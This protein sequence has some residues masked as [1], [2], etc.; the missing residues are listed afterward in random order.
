MHVVMKLF[1]VR[2]MGKKVL[3]RNLIKLRGDKEVE[4]FGSSQESTSTIRSALKRSPA[5]RQIIRQFLNR[6]IRSPYSN[7]WIVQK[8]L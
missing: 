8:I 2:I 5:D 3:S 6:S 7:V 1:Q 4:A